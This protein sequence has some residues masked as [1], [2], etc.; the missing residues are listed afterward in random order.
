MFSG[1]GGLTPSYLA[2]KSFKPL[3]RDNSTPSHPL[4]F[5]L[6]GQGMWI[7]VNLR[8]IKKKKKTVQPQIKV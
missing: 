2:K 3:G 6:Q 8:E 4:G 5:L 7:I 1:P